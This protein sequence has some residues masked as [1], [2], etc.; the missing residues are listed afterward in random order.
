MNHCLRNYKVKLELLKDILGEENPKAIIFDDMDS[1]IIGI[2]YKN[3]LPI[4]AYSYSKCLDIFIHRDGMSEEESIDFF[5]YNVAGGY[6][7]E[8]QPIIIYDDILI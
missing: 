6:L 1:A 3:D 4:L 2:S 8:H 5:A 7:G